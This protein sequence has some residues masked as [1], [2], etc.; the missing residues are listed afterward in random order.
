M[1]IGLGQALQHAVH[2]HAVVAGVLMAIN[3]AHDQVLAPSL[4]DLGTL[5]AALDLQPS[6]VRNWKA[7]SRFWCW[8]GERRRS[9]LLLL[10]R[11]QAA[12]TRR[13]E[14]KSPFVRSF[15]TGPWRIRVQQVRRY[16]KGQKSKAF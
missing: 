13:R 7:P 11:P 9:S 15:N 8:L 1:P 10:P 12:G 2:V 5:P 3:E 4:D 6:G 16:I 14:A